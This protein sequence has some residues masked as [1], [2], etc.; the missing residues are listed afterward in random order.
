VRARRITT[1]L[2]LTGAAALAVVPT[3]GAGTG[4][5]AKRTVKVRDYYLSPAAMTVKPNTQIVW[6]WPNDSGDMHDVKLVK[7]PDGVKRFHSP[8]AAV[9]FSYRRTLKKVGRYKIICTLHPDTMV[10]TIKVRR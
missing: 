6:R 3:V 9:A 7:G 10:Q 5:V 8:A 2:A 4:I 1:V